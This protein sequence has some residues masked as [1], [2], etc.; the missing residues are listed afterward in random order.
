MLKGTFLYIKK[1]NKM[2]L[3]RKYSN[4]NNALMVYYNLQSNLKYCKENK[5]FFLIIDNKL[6]KYGIYILIK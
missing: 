5:N 6:N 4:K 1:I 2:R 3:N